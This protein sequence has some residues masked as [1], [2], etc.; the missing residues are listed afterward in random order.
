[1]EYQQN[2]EKFISE[3]NIIDYSKVLQQYIEGNYEGDYK[4]LAINLIVQS[5]DITTI[6]TF[7]NEE[8]VNLLASII[9]EEINNNLEVDYYELS[10]TTL[11]QYFKEI[12][13]KTSDDAKV[14]REY[15]IS[16][17]LTFIEETL[18][19]SFALY[20]I[21]AIKYRGFKTYLISIIKLILVLV[22]ISIFNFILQYIIE[23]FVFK[24]LLDIYF[25]SV[26]WLD[27]ILLS[28]VIALV[29]NIVKNVIIKVKKKSK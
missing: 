7:A 26:I 14:K 16:L 21:I 5:E 10:K 28:M 9:E 18:Y 6:K 15:D 1:M 27:A 13:T 8:G 2:K 20:F 17:A 12:Y 24:E 4:Q 22:I 11:E 29:G 25:S 3:E 19:L 23:S